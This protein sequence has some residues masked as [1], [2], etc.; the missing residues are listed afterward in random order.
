MAKYAVTYKA[1][2]GGRSVLNVFK[3]KATALKQLRAIKKSPSFKKLGY[4]YPK[5][6]KE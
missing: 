4:S 1:K 6:R 2:N 5:I 3:N